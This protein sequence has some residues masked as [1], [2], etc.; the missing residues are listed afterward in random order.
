MNNF[1]SNPNSD[2]DDLLDQLVERFTEKVRAGETPSIVEFQQQ[3]PHLKD[4]IHELLS[5]VAMIEGLKKQSGSL[6]GS[7]HRPFDDLINL[8]RLGEY[9]IVRE[10]GRGGMGIVL[11][12]VHESL[13]RRVAIKVLPNRMLD[14]EKNV[15]RFTREARAAATL[16]HNNIVSV[17]GVGQSDGYYYYVMEFV[18]GQSLDEV[19]RAMQANTSR[20]LNATVPV[21]T[22]MMDQANQHRSN[23]EE[24][25]LN[26]NP[27]AS[28]N[29]QLENLP[30]GDA[31]F[32][33]AARLVADIADALHYAHAQGVLHRDIKPGNL[34]LDPDG[35]IWLTD[36]GL[37]KNIANQ[38]MTM[39][40]DIVGT[41][42]YMAP[43]SF[44]ARYEVPSETYCLGATLYELV[45]LQPLYPQGSPAEMIRRVTTETP[46]SPRKIDSRIPSDLSIIIE[47]SIARDPEHRYQ[48]AAAMRDDLNA[49]LDDRPIAAKRASVAKRTLLWCKR[50]PWQT[51]CAGLVGLVALLASTGFVAR[52]NSLKALS[53]QYELLSKEKDN[54]QQAKEVAEVNAQ[55]YRQQ[56][57]RAEQN[58]D[59]SLEM[60]DE[61]FKQTVL[62]GT[63]ETNFSFDGFQE[64]T[65]IETAISAED[66][67]Y[68]ES[69]LVYVRQFAVNNSENSELAA[70]SA[71]SFRRVANIYHLL[72]NYEDARK[73]YRQSANAYQR[74]NNGAPNLET[75]L[76]QMQTSNELG[77]LSINNGHYAGGI[78]VFESVR[79]EIAASPFAKEL[80]MQLE[81]VKTLNLLG[82][83]SP[84]E[85]TDAL[86]RE[87]DDA[88][89]SRSS[90]AGR[91]GFRSRLHR[92]IRTH[93][94]RNVE[95]VNKAIQ[96][97]DHLIDE[98]SDAPEA[99]PE[100]ILERAK[101]RLRLAELQFVIGM[102]P[103]S[104]NSKALAVED[105]ESSAALPELP[106]YRAVLAQAYAMPIGQDIES[107]LQD[108]TKA[109]Q[110]TTQLCNT[111]P[112]STDYLQLD[113]EVNYQLGQL[114]NETDRSEESI[115]HFQSALTSLHQT[116]QLMPRNTTIMFMI[117][118]ATASLAELLIEGKK[119]RKARDL[120]VQNLDEMTKAA[121]NRSRRSAIGRGGTT[122]SRIARQFVM[123]ATCYESLGEPIK[124]QQANQAAKDLQQK[125]R[126]EQRERA[127][128]SR[129]KGRPDR[130]DR[131]DRGKRRKRQ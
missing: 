20:D 107:A 24:F 86:A 87:R 75:A 21:Q 25:K 13:G 83:S 31:R 74:L 57:K 115:L 38:T 22:V 72:G 16:H 23:S 58:V 17:F 54:T 101:S 125:M 110:L 106:A 43:E 26:P 109:K 131:G 94:Q 129:G 100:L 36:F 79:K 48:T 64:L 128:N 65:G 2:N 121:S 52:S 93:S 98:Y 82:V 50:N 105:L 42:Q 112:G 69:M 88:R 40:G 122:R 14:N 12:A 32:G 70:E 119:F 59:I 5:S 102:K 120:L 80:P 130:G 10:L 4:E 53:Q 41:P 81:L 19:M 123:L 76:A 29:L 116:S 85:S 78:N 127:E 113:A 61:M 111:S 51:I 66:A 91:R 35:R 71:K 15:E 103:E 77:L 47:K 34:L 96:L 56:Y 126:D 104:L 84:I 60:F 68:L 49:F 45:T 18:D 95:Y 108:L 99:L 67:E 30:L 33:W 92:R 8:E 1:P 124:A 73:A 89:R 97:V 37:V 62:R 63:G 11:E 7:G 90:P 28:V 44:E 9:R 118:E 55:K 117:N 114:Y 39:A 6:A 46:H 3:H 27:S